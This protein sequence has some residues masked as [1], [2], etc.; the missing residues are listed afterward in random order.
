MLTY[1]SAVVPTVFPSLPSSLPPSISLIAGE[2]IE[3]PCQGATGQIVWYQNAVR[4]TKPSFPRMTV[5]SNGSLLIRNSSTSDSA[6]YQVLVRNQ[7]G[8]VSSL[9]VRLNVQGTHRTPLFHPSLTGNPPQLPS[10]SLQLA[11]KP[12]RQHN[13][14][15]WFHSIQPNLVTSKSV[16]KNRIKLLSSVIRETKLLQCPSREL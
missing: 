14:N 2:N 16:W 12:P 6:L 13:F 9:P 7:A 4:I 8:E 5:M 10:C 11:L 3:I 1:F 15:L